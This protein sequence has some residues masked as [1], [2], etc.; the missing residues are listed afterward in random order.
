MR[1]HP[2]L[3]EINTWPWL[4]AL[5][6]RVG[7]G[8]TLGAVPDAE[9][10]A[11]RALGIDLVYLMGLWRRSPIGR[12]LARSDPRLFDAYDRALPG[13]HVQD[14]VGSAFSIAGFEP[15]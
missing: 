8:I 14:V 9:W 10:D 5:S 3:Y 15:D 2:H 12:Q 11:L 1:P 6:R 7:R 4:D 13:W